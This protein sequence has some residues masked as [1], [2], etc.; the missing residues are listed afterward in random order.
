MHDE[1]EGSVWCLLGTKQAGG[2]D[3][4]KCHARRGRDM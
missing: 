3:I 2:L 4:Q 1:D